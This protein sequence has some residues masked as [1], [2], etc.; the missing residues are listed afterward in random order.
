MSKEGEGRRRKIE[1]GLFPRLVYRMSFAE[2]TEERIGDLSQMLSARPD[3]SFVMYINH[4]SYDDPVF[5]AHIIQRTD[6]GQTRKLIAPASYS[7]T[8]KGDH[9]NSALAFIAD[10]ARRCGIDVIP[11]IQK[12]QID[13][14]KYGFTEEQARETYQKLVEKLLEIRAA[15]IP[16]GCIISPEG[17]RSKKNEKGVACMGEAHDG[18][19]YIGKKLAPVVY[20]PVGI[21]YQGKYERDIPNIGRRVN[22]SIGEMV[23]Q[24]TRHDGPTLDTLMHNLAMAIP[25]EMRGQWR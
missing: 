15:K 6:P 22:L 3:L 17:H 24:E 25:P 11:I 5:A 2:Q 20:V 10:E 8:N 13:D 4:I 16:T 12:Y 9:R 23:V 7:H 14:P 21:W 18:I 1:I 19:L